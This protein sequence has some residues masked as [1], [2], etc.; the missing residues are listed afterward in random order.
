MMH[1]QEGDK[2]VVKSYSEQVAIYGLNTYGELHIGIGYLP[3][4][5]TM[6]GKEVTFTRYGVSVPNALYI[7]ESTGVWMVDQFELPI[8]KVHL[9]DI[10]GNF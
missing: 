9:G 2:I 3:D 8:P 1:L 5:E 7:K 10:Y 4:F 6:A